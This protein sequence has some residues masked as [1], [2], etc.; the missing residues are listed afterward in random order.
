[1]KEVTNMT[2]KANKDLVGRLK[3][4]SLASIG[5]RLANV[6]TKAAI[7]GKTNI[8]LAAGA[9]GGLGTYAA[10]RDK[11]DKSPVSKTLD[12]A[13][14]TLGKSRDWMNDNP[15]ATVGIGAAGG[16]TLSYLINKLIKS[17]RRSKAQQR[18][19]Y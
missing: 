7:P 12:K 16:L 2:I 9:A 4:A 13:K 5:K 19:Y 8:A 18:Y 1:M 6:G 15:L 3:H 10:L 11:K 17:R 14:S